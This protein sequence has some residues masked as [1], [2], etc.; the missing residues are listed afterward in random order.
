MYT[1]EITT[2]DDFDMSPRMRRLLMDM[3]IKTVEAL[4]KKF[5]RKGGNYRPI[6]YPGFGKGANQEMKKVLVSKR[7]VKELVSES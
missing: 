6:T 3:K 5:I 1:E 2:L 4:R 7:L